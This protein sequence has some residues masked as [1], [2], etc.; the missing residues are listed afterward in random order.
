VTDARLRQLER[1]FAGGERQV[2][3]D[4]VV[5]RL[6]SGALGPPALARAR[7]RLAASVEHSAA[8]VALEALDDSSPLPSVGLE[9][10][11]KRHNSYPDLV[12]PP[13][14]LEEMFVEGAPLPPPSMLERLR[15]HTRPDP[16]LDELDALAQCVPAGAFRPSEAGLRVALSA[17]RAA[18]PTWKRR[19]FPPPSREG[20]RDL[21]WAYKSLV[22][23][24]AWL[25]EPSEERLEALLVLDALDPCR[26]SDEITMAARYTKTYKLG[27]TLGMLA[28]AAIVGPR[29]EIL[30]QPSP[31]GDSKLVL[32][33]TRS[34]LTAAA[35]CAGAEFCLQILRADLSPWLLGHGDPIRRWARARRGRGA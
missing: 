31:H 3:P 21:E 27:Y 17:A 35:T 18:F 8:R 26:P 5:A 34:S 14:T 11:Q 30:P 4:L 25:L 6:R 1:A 28:R 32:H 9:A 33:C 29:R 15:R 20:P 22:A 2:E 16:W 12:T 23:A 24:Q 19:A 10:L 7:L 13:R